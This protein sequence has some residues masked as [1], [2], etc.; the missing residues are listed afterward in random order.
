MLRLKAVFAPALLALAA[1]LAGCDSGPKLCPV[2]G[3]VRFSD[4]TP[5]AGGS[6]EIRSNEPGPARNARGD[7]CPDGS[8]SLKTRLANGEK[9]GAAPGKYA[10]IVIPAFDVRGSVAGGEEVKPPIHPD[11]GRYDKSGVEIE[12]KPGGEPF[13]IR[14]RKP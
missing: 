5:L 7:I 1:A 4:G 10:V 6:V 9:E 11:M 14:V 3:F 8:F 12:V 13:E 2:R